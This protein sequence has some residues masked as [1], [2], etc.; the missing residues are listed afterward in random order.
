MARP[1]LPEDPAL[2]LPDEVARD[3]CRQGGDILHPSDDLPRDATAGM[4]RSMPAATPQFRTRAVRPEPGERVQR[5]GADLGAALSPGRVRR[6]P[7]QKRGCQRGARLRLSR[8][9]CRLRPVP[10]RSRRPA[11]HPRRAQPGRAAPRS[12]CCAR[13]SPERRSRS[14]SSPPM[15]SAGRSIRPV[16]PSGPRAAR[17]PDAEQTRV[18]PLVDELRRA[19]EPIAHPRPMGA[20]QGS[21]RRR[22]R[23]PTEILCVN[24]ITGTQNGASPAEANPGT[25]VPTADFKSATLE[26][27]RRSARI[28][29]RACCSLTGPSRR[30]AHSC[31]RAT[32]ITSTTTPC[33]GARSGGDAERRLAAWQR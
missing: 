5:R 9:L 13:K 30:S 31:C 6:L 29:T 17:V 12:G 21:D 25:L 11:D 14:A 33:S 4:H 15:S 19:G 1:G 32:I 18:H 22:T 23:R 3:R 10:E 2:W 16:R 26:P 20:H 28:A 24:P 8:R 7:A 27:R